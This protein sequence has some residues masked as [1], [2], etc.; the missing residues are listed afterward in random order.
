MI[1]DKTSNDD[2]HLIPKCK[3]GKDVIRIH[4][5]CHRK[6]HSLWTEKEL[7]DYYHTLTRIREHDEM[8]KF[9]KWVS[10]KPDDYYSGTKD[11]NVR[12]SKRRR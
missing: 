6:I 1:D 11:S 2:H 5:I 10:K 7:V 8:I 9:I 4:K 12:K 3:K